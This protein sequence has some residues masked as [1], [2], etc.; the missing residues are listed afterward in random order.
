MDEQGDWTK[1]RS[2]V[3]GNTGRGKSRFRFLKSFKRLFFFSEENT[4]VIWTSVWSNSTS[5]QASKGLLMTTKHKKLKSIISNHLTSAQSSITTMAS[6]FLGSLPSQGI[7]LR[8]QRVTMLQSESHISKWRAWWPKWWRIY[9][10][11][12]AF[13]CGPEIMNIILI[14]GQG[15]AREMAQ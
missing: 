11:R 4:L 9:M 7:R 5:C 2:Q 15:N 8:Y 3:D 14:L 10:P 6:S 1:S 12:M 13:Q